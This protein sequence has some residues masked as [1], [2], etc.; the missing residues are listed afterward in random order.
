MAQFT[1]NAQ[2][3]DPYKNFKFRSSGTAATSP[4]SARSAPS[5]A[6]P[7]SSSTARAATRTS[8][9]S[10]GRTK[11]EPITLERGVTHDP[12]FEQWANKVWNFGAGLG[13]EVSLA[14]L[15]QGHDHR[16]L[17]RGR[18]GR[19]RL[20]AS[21]AAGCP[22]TRRCP[23][24]TPTRTRSR[25]SRSSS[26]TRAGSATTTWP[27][28]PSR[29]S[30]SPRRPRADAPSRAPSISCASG[31]A[32]A[33]PH[34]IDRALPARSASAGRGASC[35]SARATRRLLRTRA[36]TFGDRLEAADECPGAA[37]AGR[38]AV[39]RA[40]SCE[41]RRAAARPLDGR[42]RRPARHA[43]PARQRRRRR[44]GRRRERRRG[45]RGA[46]RA[47]GAW[48]SSA[49]GSRCRRTPPAAREP[50]R[51]PRRGRPGAELLID[52]TCPA[53]AASWQP[54]LDVA[55]FVWAELDARARAAARAR[56]TRSRRVRLDRGRGPRA[57]RRPARR[58]PGAGERMSDFLGRLAARQLGALPGARPRPAARFEPG[59]PS[60]AGAAAGA[61]RRRSRRRRRSPRSRP[62]RREPPTPPAAD[63][64]AGRAAAGDEPSRGA[65]AA[66]VRTAPAASRSRRAEPPAAPAAEPEAPRAA[67]PRP[68]PRR[69]SRCR[70]RASRGP[71]CRD[72]PRAEP[73]PPRRR[74]AGRAG[75]PRPPP[76]PAAVARLRPAPLVPRAAH[77][78]PSPSRSPRLAPQ[79]PADA[80]RAG[81]PGHD[82]PARGPRA[83]A[84]PPRPSARPGRAPR[85]RSTTY[86]DRGGARVS[87]A[88]AIA[89]V[90]A[91][92]RGLLDAWLQDHDANSALGGAS[93]SVT[94]LP[95]DT[96]ELTGANAEP[97]AQPLP[98]PG[99]R[100]TRPCAT[101]TCRRATPAGAA[102][103]ARRWRS[104]CTTC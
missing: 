53:C 77:A 80:R 44:G 69:S 15:P 65:R 38:L 75:R 28:R 89:G 46:A 76:A 103:R 17:Q 31:S 41:R 18:P 100:P 73:L 83:V 3:F 48:P 22:S 52:L 71:G 4:A 6:R 34:P 40:R 86:L 37:S 32:G 35:R 95:P 56:C 9:K 66:A 5:S 82:R 16:V 33:A 92:L 51:W 24:S 91:V 79:P 98:V 7:R 42:A 60:R 36:A 87:N 90:T 104:T 61:R 39:L 43:A 13:A 81:R 19:A 11:Y 8:R 50:R 10:P 25:S 85:S 97:E 88:L 26:R 68:S 99:R 102:R 96:I 57:G 49:D 63:P 29:S 30:P 2:R 101:P 93:A 67:A 55:G 84:A 94:A 78:A 20:Q 1:V 21:T 23:T 70:P 27:S 62:R 59:R 45:A 54:V 72:A 14:G 12:E 64:A 47:R 58:V 74:R